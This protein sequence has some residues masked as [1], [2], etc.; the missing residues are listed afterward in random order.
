MIGG[1]DLDGISSFYI[2]LRLKARQRSTDRAGWKNRGLQDG[3]YAENGVDE[4]H[5]PICCELRYRAN[6]SPS[7]NSGKRYRE[8][9]IT[10]TA[11]SGMD[12]FLWEIG[13]PDTSWKRILGECHAE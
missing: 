8:Y 10:D 2:G 3:M 1:P 6:L 13:V 7:H 12:N 5:G 9:W 4:Q 11:S